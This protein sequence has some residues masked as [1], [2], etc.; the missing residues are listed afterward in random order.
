MARDNAKRTADLTDQANNRANSK[1]PSLAAL[2]SA[3]GGGT[4]IS[5]TFLTGASGVDPGSLKLSK[6]TLLGG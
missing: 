1:A 3:N 5:S 6:T 2:M 4:G